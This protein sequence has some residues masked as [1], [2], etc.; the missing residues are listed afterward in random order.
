VDRD[1][2]K[3]GEV[4]FSQIISLSSQSLCPCIYLT[5]IPPIYSN[6]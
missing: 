4:L 5:S 2:V 1:L 3:Q 6:K